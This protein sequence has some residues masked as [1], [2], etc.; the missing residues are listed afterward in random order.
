MPNLKLH[1][2]PDIALSYLNSVRANRCCSTFFAT[3]CCP[4]T[5]GGSIGVCD[6]EDKRSQHGCLPLYFSESQSAMMRTLRENLNF[7]KS[8][9]ALKNLG[10]EQSKIKFQID[11]TLKF[12][13]LAKER[14]SADYNNNIKGA[15]AV[16]KSY[17]DGYLLFDAGPDIQAMEFKQPNKEEGASSSLLTN[18]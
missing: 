17:K 14:F 1:E 4:V 3:L 15:Y 5:L 6:V 10:D 9:N 18:R 8:S 11:E 16:I 13:D 7:L 12:L 2:A